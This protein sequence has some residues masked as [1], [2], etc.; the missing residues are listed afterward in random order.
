MS[1]VSYPNEITGDDAV[2]GIVDTSVHAISTV[3]QKRDGA[4]INFDPFLCL[5]LLNKAPQGEKHVSL[6]FVVHHFNHDGNFI[7]KRHRPRAKA[8]HLDEGAVHV[9]VDLKVVFQ[10][11]EQWSNVLSPDGSP[12]LYRP[13]LCHMSGWVVRDMSLG[14]GALMNE[15]V[16]DVA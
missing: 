2:V 13:V 7:K 5:R 12:L 9:Q 14:N 15:M 8:R 10:P 16:Q 1:H 4:V 6:T 11:F 3:H